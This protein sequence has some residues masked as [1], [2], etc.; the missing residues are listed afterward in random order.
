MQTEIENE[1]RKKKCEIEGR[2]K[3]N[4]LDPEGLIRPKTILNPEDLTQSNPKTGSNQL[5]PASGVC[6]RKLE[7]K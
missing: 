3:K 7:M 6:N 2:Q 1:I 5:A 4:I